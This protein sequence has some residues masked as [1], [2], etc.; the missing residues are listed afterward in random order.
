MFFARSGVRAGLVSH[1]AAGFR[2]QQF[3]GAASKELLQTPNPIAEQL[4][5]TNLWRYG[6]WA[7]DS[8]K[9][10]EK[11]KKFKGDKA[12]VNVTDEKLCDDIIEYMR[13]TLD[14]HI[15]CDIV[16]LFPGAGLW[17]RKLHNA[18]QPRSHLLLE[19]D[20]ALYTPMLKELLERPNTKLIPKSG[21]VWAE[22]SEVLNKTYLP[23]QVE[24]PTDKTPERNDTLLVTANLSFYPKKKYAFFDNIAQLLLYQFISAI[25]TGS[26][27]QKYGLVRMLIWVGDDEKNSVLSRNIQRRKRLSVEAEISTEYIAEIAGADG[28]SING[29][30]AQGP[31]VRDHNIDLE[32]TRMAL[33][34]TKRQGISMPPGRETRMMREL[35]SMSAKQRKQI[36][37][38]SSPPFFDRAYLGELAELEA[39]KEAGTLDTTDSKRVKR[40]RDL[41]YKANQDTRRSNMIHELLVARSSMPIELGAISDSEKRAEWTAKHSAWEERIN[42]MDKALRGDFLLSRDNL[43]IFRQDPPVLSWDRRP[44]EPLVVSG[45][46]F[47]PNVPCALLDIQP[48]TMHPL[49][50]ESG[51][52][53]SRAGDIFGI[54]LGS[55]YRSSLDPLDK[56]LESIYPG[57]AEGVLPYCPSLVDPKVGGAGYSGWSGLSP[58]ALNEKQ[59]VEILDAW[60]KWPFRPGFSELVGR[61]AEDGDYAGDEEGGAVQTGDF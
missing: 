18:V 39:E 11:K 7:K 29:L 34:R 31:F 56:V 19:P 43:H 54:L 45:M 49:L 42:R 36:K 12:R 57:A 3:R 38:G 23:H 46:E 53:T 40:L 32:S 9:S 44:V 8:D 61:G 35:N 22:L 26:L 28:M 59:L 25:R 27:F 41:K 48:K 21:I 1:T 14:R 4:N 10:G 60:M 20:E 58:R 17:S 13:P 2:W 30:R 47:F 50:L 52:N 55:M 15:G 51:P 6:R 33:D 24:Q 16:D 5:A 37:A